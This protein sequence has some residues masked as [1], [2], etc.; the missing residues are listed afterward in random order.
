[1]DIIRKNMTTNQQ[2]DEGIL[3]AELS[4]GNFALPVAYRPEYVLG[5]G[6]FGVV[7]GV[8]IEGSK[9]KYAVKKVGDAFS[10]VVDA[11]RLF[12]ET[13]IM[14]HMRHPNLLP[15]SNLYMANEDVY[16]V[17]PGMDTNLKRVVEHDLRKLS[18]R[19]IKFI[20]FQILAGLD[21]LH[22]SDVVHR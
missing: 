7:I 16:V 6:G 8:S 3:T 11:K 9:K 22:A 10:N 12:R 5:H 1:M 15:L 18:L 21:F 2:G 13:R 20:L 19:H 4:C 17:S 14:Q